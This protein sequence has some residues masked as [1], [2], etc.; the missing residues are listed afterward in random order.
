MRAVCGPR[1]GGSERP[2]CLDMVSRSRMRYPTPPPLTPL[3]PSDDAS[4]LTRLGRSV[5][6]TRL[7]SSGNGIVHIN[8]GVCIR[9]LDPEVLKTPKEAKATGDSEGDAPSPA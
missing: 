5:G 9:T 4:S 3:L 1:A 7:S 6:N 2:V 8:I